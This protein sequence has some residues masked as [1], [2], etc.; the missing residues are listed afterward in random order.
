MLRLLSWRCFPLAPQRFGRRFA[1]QHPV[2]DREASQLGEA[3]DTRPE[4]RRILCKF[5][6]SIL[7]RCKASHIF[8][9]AQTVP[10]DV[11][12]FDGR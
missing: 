7:S 2:F 11:A 12:T 4:Q 8:R 6:S 9:A 10:N 5:K 3:I 1:K